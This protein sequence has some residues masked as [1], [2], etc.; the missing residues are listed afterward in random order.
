MT[1]PKPST[2]GERIQPDRCDATV[3]WVDSA[4]LL[5]GISEIVAAY[6]LQA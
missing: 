1:T 5:H 4:A 2:A 6:R 3:Y